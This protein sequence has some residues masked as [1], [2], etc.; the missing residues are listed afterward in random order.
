[1]LFRVSLA[2]EKHLIMVLL[3]LSFIKLKRRI[4]LKDIENYQT[5]KKIVKKLP[6]KK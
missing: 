3:I 4:T 2:Q 6:L 5:K 1:M